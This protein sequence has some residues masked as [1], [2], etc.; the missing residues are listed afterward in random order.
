MLVLFLNDD[1]RAKATWY[2]GLDFE[3]RVHALRAKVNCAQNGLK[4][5]DFPIYNSPPIP[6]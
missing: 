3:F 2:K 1:L 5:N 6:S 4:N